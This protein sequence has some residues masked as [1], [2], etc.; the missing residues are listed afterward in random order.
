MK[1]LHIA[2]FNGN[3]GDNASHIGLRNILKALGVTAQI[4]QIEI[5]RFYKNYSL[6]DK[7]SFNEFFVKKANQYDLV[8]FGGGGFL[9]YWVPNSETGTTIDITLE[10]FQKLTVPVLFTSI[11]CIP[12]R[13]VPEGNIEKFCRFINAIL[14]KKNAAIAVRNDG[15]KAVLK[16]V[17]GDS[18]AN[19]IP[20]ILD[21]GFFYEPHREFSRIVDS[22]YIAINVTKDQLLMKNQT[23]GKVNT[24]HFHNQ[25]KQYI[26]AVIKDT[27]FNI[28]FVPHIYSDLEAIQYALNGVNDYLL[29]TRVIVAPYIQGD[30]GCEYLMSVYREADYIVGMRF[31]ANVCSLAQGK[32]I[33]GLA[34][35]D[36]I[37]YMCQSVGAGEYVVD[38]NSDF[39]Q[40]LFDNTMVHVGQDQ[41]VSVKKRINLLKQES[42]QFYKS[43]FSNFL[44]TEKGV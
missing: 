25:L 27:N 40:L 38:V 21:N 12:H 20:Q 28:V 15:S 43:V 11:G 37:K 8:I 23:I 26:C 22:R 7:Q 1:V 9:D 33:A 14:R 19:K 16:T 30:Y 5:R 3:I 2:S 44:F 18:V 10:L 6:P 42:L 31:H 41:D 4:K 13:E 17:L 39:A 34:A 36:R 29:R 32:S 24:E 35:L